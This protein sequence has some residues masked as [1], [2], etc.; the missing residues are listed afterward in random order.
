MP[1]HHKASR[2]TARVAPYITAIGAARKAGLT[3][4]DLAE[5]L[6]EA[7]P[8]ALR[9]AVKQCQWTAEQMP[10]PPPPEPPAQQVARQQQ[11]MPDA[12]AAP[13][14]PIARMPLPATDDTE[15]VIN[16]HLIK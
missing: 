9:Q 2:A 15:S 1:T 3:W 6:G 10:L 7:G 12:K 13:S 5:I 4:R 14:A 8:D 16:K 11:P